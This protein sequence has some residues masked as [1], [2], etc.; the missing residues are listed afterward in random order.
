MRKKMPTIQKLDLANQWKN[1][2][3][4]LIQSKFTAVLKAYNSLNNKESLYAKTIA[5]QCDLY[6]QTITLIDNY[7]P[8]GLAKI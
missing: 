4:N 1:E 3:R 8:C 7:K 5:Q 2:F 6:Q